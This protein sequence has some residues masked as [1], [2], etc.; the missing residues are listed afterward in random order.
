MYPY[1][2]QVAQP[3]GTLEK[4]NIFNN[5]KALFIYRVCGTVQNNTDSILI[6]IMVGTIYV[7]YYS[8]YSLIIVQVTAIVTLIFNSV[9][10]SIGNAIAS[11]NDSGASM[12]TIF[13]TLELINFW[14]VSFCSVC[15]IVLFQDFTIIFY[16]KDYLLNFSAVLS[17]V[18]NF[19]TSNIRQNIWTFRETTG[20]FEE[21]KYIT[22][23]TAVLN[24]GLSLI[25]GYY[26]GIAGIL[27]A[28]VIARTIYAFWKEPLILFHRFFKTNAKHYFVTY[29][30]RLLLCGLLC[31]LT[32]GI[33]TQITISNT[34]LNFIIKTAL[35]LIVPNAMLLLIYYR[36]PEFQYVKDKILLP[37]LHKIVKH[38]RK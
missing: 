26:W 31:L 30:R 15:F 3:L 6:S 28:T 22:A 33:C 16:G 18:L 5:V 19:Y 25:M 35:C 29:G 12:V 1:L 14:I 32:Y 17:M 23:V 37:T 2:K 21:T 20:L 27:I 9:K 13:N 7:G 10:A 36:T 38:R 4:K 34:Y 8:N 24:L 11:N